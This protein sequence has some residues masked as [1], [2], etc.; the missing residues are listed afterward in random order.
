M[1][2]RKASHAGSWY[3][4]NGQLLSQQLDGWLGAVPASTTPIGSASSQKGQVSIP[5]PSA[6]AIIAPHAGYSYSGPAAAWAY[7]SADWAN[8]KRVFL[9]GPSHHYYLTGAATTGCDKYHTPLGDLIV[10][11]TL[12]QTIQQEWDLEIMSKRTDEDE[13]SLEMHLPYIYKM[14]SLKNSDFQSDSSSVPLIPIMVGNTDAA[15]ETRYGSLLAP[16]LADPTNIFVIS[17][18]FCHWGS[19]FRYTYYQPPNGAAATQLKSASRVPS[20]YPI[21]ESIAAVDHE[22]MD[23]I[24]TGSHRKFLDQLR[25]TGNTVCGRHP[26]G[27]FMAAVES[28]E[29]LEEGKGIFSFLRYERSSLVEDLQ[30]SSVSYCS[31]FAVL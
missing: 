20:D 7:K 27:L 12:V 31:A 21:H 10:D 30:D 28:T 26:I 4:D 13:H 15:A 16:Y 14:L 18:D 17:S 22:S 23:A 24:E 1:V 11:T 25:K 2:T 6:R 19:R 3:T 9:L 29:A 8:A 5:T